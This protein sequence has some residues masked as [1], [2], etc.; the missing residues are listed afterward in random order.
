MNEIKAIEASQMK[1]KPDDFKV[2]D[3]FSYLALLGR[4]KIIK[5]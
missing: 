2:G 4:Y 5:N 3:R 1:E